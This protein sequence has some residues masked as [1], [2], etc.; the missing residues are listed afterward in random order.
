MKKQDTHWKFSTKEFILLAGILVAV[1]IMFTVWLSPL[2]EYT[3]IEVPLLPLP[4]IEIPSTEK[5]LMQ[6]VETFHYSVR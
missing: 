2:A 3:K 4:A 1:I 6:I 5:I